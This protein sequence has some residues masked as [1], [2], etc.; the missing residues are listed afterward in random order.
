M[1]RRP[2]SRRM[3]RRV[4]FRRSI[5]GWGGWN[6]AL[7][8]TAG[9]WGVLGPRLN[10]N[11]LPQGSRPEALAIEDTVQP[12]P[13]RSSFGS[14]RSSQCQNRPSRMSDLASQYGATRGRTRQESRKTEGGD[15]RRELRGAGP[16]GTCWARAGL[17]REAA[18]PQSGQ[19]G[20]SLERQ[21]RS[22][23]DPGSRRR[24]HEEASWCRAGP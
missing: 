21:C 23:P 6:T 9:F 16:R 18:A 7:I 24:Y 13:S 10:P 14:H 22:I 4:L 5:R 12:A 1:G 2:A 17:G 3:L 8:A 19:R 11:P 15:R 20:P